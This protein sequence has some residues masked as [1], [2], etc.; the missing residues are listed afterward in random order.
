M[1]ESRESC[2]VA[3]DVGGTRM[4][5]GLVGPDARIIAERLYDT[6]RADGPAAVTDRIVGAVRD[7]RG[8]AAEHGLRPTGAGVVIPGIIDEAE[9]V[10]RSSANIGWTDF[11]LRD[12]LTAHTD[13][14]VEI[15]HDVRAGGLAESV[16]GAGKGESD[17]LFLALGTG[18][19]G[20][21]ILE[22][23]PFSGGGY[24]GEIGH[25][26]IDPGGYPCGC[27]SRGCLETVASASAV[28]R[29]YSER[30][31]AR[32][33]AHEVAALVEAC[34]PTAL[35]V[36]TD[37]V[38]ALAT[39]I[40]AYMTICA[41]A[42]VVIGGGLAQSGETLLS[43]LRDLVTARTTYHRPVEIVRASLGDR[44]GLLGAAL[45]G[46]AAAPHR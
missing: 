24:G 43:P 28:G 7:L 18:I 8:Q 17:L 46:G 42:R 10:V 3:L 35:G 44:A 22:G 33:A 45:L 15:G 13:M 23:R 26:L 11:P 14:P 29:R 4:K 27:G 2:V 25:M 40:L 41:P 5:A 38:E 21:M 34:E 1:P 30:A 31:G 20:A 32:T 12:H 19:A 39:A 9:G 36:W 6:G 16:L 37:A